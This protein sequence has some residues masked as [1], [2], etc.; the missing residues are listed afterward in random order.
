MNQIAYFKFFIFSLL[1]SAFPLEA[2]LLKPSQDGGKKEIIISDNGIG[3]TADQLKLS[4]NRH[5][6]SKLPENNLNDINFLGF[7]GEALPSIA[8]ISEL[9]I[10]SCKKDLNEGWCIELKK[11]HINKFQPSP[12]KIGTKIIVKNV[13]QNV[14]ARLKF[15]KSNQVENKNSLQIIKKI[16]LGHPEIKFSY[17]FEENLS[18]IYKKENLNRGGFKQRILEVFQDDFFS[19]SFPISCDIS[20]KL[21]FEPFSIIK[22]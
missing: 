1:L 3:M 13:F 8:S 12:I 20:S 4:I 6:T 11:N 21:K 19:N 14:P 16:A 15:L 9:K 22:L 17:K 7:R 5:A 18:H 2:K 10:E